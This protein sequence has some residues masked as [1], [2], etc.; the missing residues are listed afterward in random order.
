MNDTTKNASARKAGSY[1]L[2]HDLIICFVIVATGAFSS[3]NIAKLAPALGIISDTYSLS[4]SAVGLLASILSLVT[5]LFGLLLGAISPAFGA[6]RIFIFALMAGVIG[7]IVTIIGDS[8]LALFIGRIIEGIALIIT[9][10]VAPVLLTHYTSQSRRGLI[11]GLWGGFMP[12]GNAMALFLAPIFI[13][14]GQWQPLW[15]VGIIA[16]IILLVCVLRLIPRDANSPK[17]S[18]DWDAVITAVKLPILLVVGLSFATHGLVY[19]TLLQLLPLFLQ[20]VSGANFAL[21]SVAVA[22]FCLGNFVGNV[23]IGRL[24]DFNYSVF[25]LLAGAYSCVC[26]SLLIAIQF[27][28]H[29][30][31]LLPLLMLIALCL[32][33]AAPILFYLVSR[34]VTRP[35]NLPACMGWMLQIQ[36]L[37]L[38]LG[39]SIFSFVIERFNS[40]T[41]G[42]YGIAAV[43]LLQL[44][45]SRLLKKLSQA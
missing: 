37:G 42:L 26:V 2:R 33:A 22:I 5:V 12:F 28:A 17:L 36:G 34:A 1:S 35:Q 19:Q 20:Q 45:F 44:V 13:T 32:G 41:A 10:L 6:R 21:A 23:L 30:F 14:E 24:I 25:K 31:I 11:I 4:L 15:M 43:A 39:P 16:A 7:G 3:F 9:M 40:W 29:L 38:L 8:V 18:F 27:Q